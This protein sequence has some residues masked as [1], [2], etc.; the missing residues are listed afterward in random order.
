MLSDK[1]LQIRESL[2]DEDYRELLAT[3]HV[4]TTLAL[5]IRKLRERRQWS[6]RDLAEKLGKHQETISQW[7]DPDYGRYTTKTMQAIAKAFDVALMQKFVS[8]SELA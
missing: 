6:Q 1:E 8:F 4:N 5:Q 7:E 3:E 2:A